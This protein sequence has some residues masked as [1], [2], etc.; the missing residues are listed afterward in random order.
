MPTM[1]APPRVNYVMTFPTGSS[2]HEREYLP[3][4]DLE[5]VVYMVI[6]LIGLLEPDLPTLIKDV[7]IYSF[8]S[9]FLQSREDFLE[10]MVDVCT[11]TC[12]PSRDCPLGSHDQEEVLSIVLFLCGKLIKK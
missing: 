10:A 6:S 4:H 1:S 12:I 5:L 8:Q 11:L 7:K 2:L 3:S 9:V